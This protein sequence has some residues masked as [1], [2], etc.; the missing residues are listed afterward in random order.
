MLVGIVSKKKIAAIREKS[1]VRH[2]P[3]RREASHIRASCRHD[4][5]NDRTKAHFREYA[6]LTFPPSAM[7]CTQAAIDAYAIL[8]GR[9]SLSGGAQGVATR[10]GKLVVSH[11]RG[12]ERR[13]RRGAL[14]SPSSVGHSRL[15]L[16]THAS[17]IDRHQRSRSVLSRSW[18]ASRSST[19]RSS[20]HVRNA[21][22]W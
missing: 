18:L 14:S 12:V 4:D 17:I 8:D 19:N 9:V 22:M 3:R 16:M 2:P 10:D 1:H 13:V 6:I 11:R 15:G 7:A 5:P 21:L 20:Y